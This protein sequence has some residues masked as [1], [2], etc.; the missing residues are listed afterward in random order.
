M[1]VKVVDA[2]GK[3]L[4]PTTAEKARRLLAQGK[5]ELVSREPFVIRLPYTVELPERL[6][7]E[8]LPGI[9]KRIL[10]H[11]CCGPCATYTVQR[12]REQGFAVV[13]FW[14]NPNIHPWQ[15]HEQRRESAAKLAQEIDLP[16]IWY[17][18]YEMPQFLR[19]VVGR[20][21]PGQR[22]ALCYRMRLERTAQMATQGRFDAF[23]TTLLISPHQDQQLIHRESMAARYGVG[24]YFENFRRGWGER[25]RL[26][27]QH[28][29]YRQQYCGC[30]YSEWERYNGR[31][32]EV[33]L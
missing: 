20:E 23:T 5:A 17:G 14:Y 33:L 10:L 29:L 26:T 2:E 12:L 25:G 1:A 6:E 24:F 22:C 11:I 19:L 8:P 32:V 31:S 9:G 13:G 30:I 28:D 3:E 15:E 4:A 21:K 27:R 16:V 7:P 18:R